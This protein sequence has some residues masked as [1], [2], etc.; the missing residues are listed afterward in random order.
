[1]L[2]SILYEYWRQ[3]IIKQRTLCVMMKRSVKYITY[4]R[5]RLHENLFHLAYD[6]KGENKEHPSKYPSALHRCCAG[7]I[8]LP[9][10]LAVTQTTVFFAPNLQSAVPSICAFIPTF[11]RLEDQ[12]RNSGRTIN[13]KKRRGGGLDSLMHLVWT[14]LSSF[15]N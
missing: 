3:I 15:F 2:Q 1:M 10:W 4:T 7:A 11:I 9:I 6:A 5:L 13:T 12:T 8:C 14:P